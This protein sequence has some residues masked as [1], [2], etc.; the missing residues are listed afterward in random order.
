MSLFDCKIW[1]QVSLLDG[2]I[3]NNLAILSAFRWWAAVFFFVVVVNFNLQQRAG[4]RTH[5][6]D[7]VYLEK[8]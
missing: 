4:T 8:K 7:V 2:E 6:V 5:P 1:Q 3:Q